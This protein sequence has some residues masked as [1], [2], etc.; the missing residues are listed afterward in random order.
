VV[1]GK[2]RE[3]KGLGNERERKERLRHNKDKNYYYK[4][5]PPAHKSRGVVFAGGFE[6]LPYSDRSC[7]CAYLYNGIH[8]IKNPYSTT[9]PPNGKGKKGNDHGERQQQPVDKGIDAG[10]K[11]ALPVKSY[12]K[13]K[14]PALA[15]RG[16]CLCGRV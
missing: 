4:D 7:S 10:W 14:P 3:Q 16:F 2:D 8:T 1:S 15:S 9:N 13:D 12:Y 6:P 5:N 11:P